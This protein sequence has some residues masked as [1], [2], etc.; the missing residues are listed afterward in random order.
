MLTF[1]VP[2]IPT[3]PGQPNA[4][5]ITTKTQTDLVFVKKKKKVKGKTRTVKIP[6]IGAPTSA[7]ASGWRT[8]T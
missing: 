3:L 8:A 4:A 7:P 1:D 5:V 6:L 2:D